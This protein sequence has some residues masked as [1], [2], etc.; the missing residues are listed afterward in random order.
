[1]Y[2]YLALKSSDFSVPNI[3]HPAAITTADTVISSDLGV[4]KTLS[5]K[6]KII[7]KLNMTTPYF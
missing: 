3:W 6:G 4:Y 2:L 5:N 1:M 7:D